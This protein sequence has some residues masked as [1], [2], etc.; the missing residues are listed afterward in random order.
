MIPP[1]GVTAEQCMHVVPPSDGAAHCKLQTVSSAQPSHC[2]WNLLAG[3]DD[4]HTPLTGLRTLPVETQ[5]IWVLQVLQ[6]RRIKTVL[7][8]HFVYSFKKTPEVWAVRLWSSKDD[9]ACSCSQKT[10]CA[11]VRVTVS[12][13]CGS[14]SNSA[15]A[16]S[17]HGSPA[18]PMRRTGMH[19]L[20]HPLTKLSNLHLAPRHSTVPMRM[21]TEN[22]KWVYVTY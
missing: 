16:R 5:I 9:S 19:T 3:S 8:C 18:G 10:V 13:V 11:A 17:V 6:E 14:A 21:A 4:T 2:D 22:R 1:A 20:Q 7:Q 12:A 15:A